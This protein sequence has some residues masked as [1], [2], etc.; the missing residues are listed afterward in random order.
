MFSLFVVVS[1]SI[2]SLVSAS[3]IGYDAI[4]AIVIAELVF[5][6][7]V[8]VVCIVFSFN[9]FRTLKDSQETYGNL[10]TGD[11]PPRLNNANN[12]SSQNNLVSAGTDPFDYSTFHE[13][14]TYSFGSEAEMDYEGRADDQLPDRERESESGNMV[15]VIGTFGSYL[16]FW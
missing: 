3:T 10:P 7:S 9:L 14:E 11:L 13:R 8:G 15:A 1:L 4:L 2:L 16:K 5:A 6:F 12:K